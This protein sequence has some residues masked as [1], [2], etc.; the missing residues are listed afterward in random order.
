MISPDALGELGATP[1]EAADRFRA[2]L[3]RIPDDREATT[4]LGFCLKREAPRPGDPKQ[5]GLERVKEEYE[6]T[7]FRQLKSMLEKK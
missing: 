7:V 2:V 3:E 5:E 4:L 1:D 6:E